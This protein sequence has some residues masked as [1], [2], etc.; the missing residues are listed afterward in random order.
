MR[1]KITLVTGASRG[2]GRGIAHELGVAGATVYIT[3]RSREGEATTDDLPGTIDSTARLVT[4]AG[5]KGIAVACDH[6][7]NEDVARLAAEIQGRHGRLDVLVNNVWGGYEQYDADLFALPVWEQP[8][9]RWDKMF[10]TGVRAHYLTTRAVLPLLLASPRATIANI[11]FGDE[12]RFLGDVQYDVAKYAVTRL[13]FALA[14]ALA[15]QAIPVVTV[16]PGFTRTE[17]VTAEAPA[18]QLGDTH[19]ARFVGRAIVALASDPKLRE[20]S[21]GA[22]KVGDLG[23][24][25]GFTDVDGSQPEPFSLP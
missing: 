6:T 20:R 8:I 22:F 25:Y 4:E 18:E 9:W 23:F 14:E 24:D 5:G 10:D 15:D 7:V 21:G 1:D 16:Y 11:S 17:R 2:V 13:G 12:G 19:S 3:G